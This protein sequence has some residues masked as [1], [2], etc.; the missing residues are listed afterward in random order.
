[1]RNKKNQ[2][3]KYENNQD[4]HFL[5]ANLI[6][7]TF[8]I[9]PTRLRRNKRLR[10]GRGSA[11]SERSR[12]M[13][14]ENVFVMFVCRTVPAEDKSFAVGVQYMLFRVLGECHPAGFYQLLIFK[15]LEHHD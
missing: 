9:E 11:G 10:A 5:T 7:T 6:L 1:M 3:D 14:T 8:L 12:T 15:G 4:F 2:T 13:K